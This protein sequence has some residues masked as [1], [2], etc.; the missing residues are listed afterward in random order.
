MTSIQAR[1]L[2]WS[3]LLAFLDCFSFPYRFSSR[4][5]QEKDSTRWVDADEFT[6]STGLMSNRVTKL[7]EEINILSSTCSLA[8]KTPPTD[9]SAERI[10][11]LE[12]ELAETKKVRLLDMLIVLLIIVF[13]L[14]YF[15]GGRF[16]FTF[17]CGKQSCVFFFF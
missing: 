1:A 7:E 9:P 5:S 6:R 2:L 10:K 16:P 8:T 11:S 4:I 17:Y 12:A 3:L 14:N 15:F 13:C